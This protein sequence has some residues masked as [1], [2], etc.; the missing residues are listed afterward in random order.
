MCTITTATA[1]RRRSA[2]WQAETIDELKSAGL[3]GQQL[4]ALARNCGTESGKLSELALI[5][6]GYETLLAHT[7]MDPADR[8]EL[9][10]D[11][12]EAA[13]AAGKLPEF[14]RDRAVFVDEFDTFNA[15]KKRLMGAMLAALP[16]VTVA[17]CDDGTPLQPEDLSLFSGAKQVAAQLRQLARRSGTE[18]AVP[19]LLRRDMRHADAPASRQRPAAGV[20]PVRP[21]PGLPGNKAL[22]RPQPGGGSPAAAAAIRRLMRRRPLRQ[23]AV[24]CRD[25]AKY[26][27]AVRYEFRMA[28]HSPLL[29]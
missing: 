29:R 20:G 17:L 18:V 1:A 23:V 11:R 28:D 13:L 15:P 2:R 25:I 6:Q 19:E 21:A 12:L 9:A 3:S 24:V 4:Y 5:F 27:A 16:M 7:G 14:L 26:R 22:R 8:L 10:A